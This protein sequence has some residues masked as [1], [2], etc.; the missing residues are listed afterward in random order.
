[1][2]T[3]EEIKKAKEAIK[4]T[5]EAIKADLKLSNTRERSILK[6]VTLLK[7]FFNQSMW[8]IPLSLVVLWSSIGMFATNVLKPV[9]AD[10]VLVTAESMPPEIP[11]TNA[12][13]LFECA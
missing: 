12:S 1:M 13:T 11:I 10:N 6:S 4:K 8:F 3:K 2:A 9:F 5:D 7:F